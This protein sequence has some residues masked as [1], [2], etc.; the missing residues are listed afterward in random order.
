MPAQDALDLLAAAYQVEVKMRHRTFV[1]DEN[2]GANLASLAGL[3][4]QPVPRSGVMCC[5]NCGNGKTTLLRAFS[6]TVD[7]LQLR[8]HFDFLSDEYTRYKARV[9]MFGARDLV[10]MAADA[11]RFGEIKNRPILAIDDL[12]T[13]PLEKRDFGDVLTPIV[14][15]IEYRY[16]R[17]LFTFMTTNL[18]GRQ[19]REKYG[20][21]VADRLNEMVGTI[22]FRDISYRK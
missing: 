22:V 14:E 2:T 15:L 18:V 21:R 4:T 17:Q 10:R 7:Y 16:S 3:L 5:G 6:R 11:E 13:E 9:S 8:H 20:D 1:L 19:I 12:G